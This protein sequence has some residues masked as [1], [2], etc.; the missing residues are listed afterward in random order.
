MSR[1]DIGVL[2]Y[3]HFPA[4][5]L[6]TGKESVSLPSHAFKK[7]Y[8]YTRSDR[9]GVEKWIHRYMHTLHTKR[10]D[11][12]GIQNEDPYPAALT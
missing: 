11:R 1:L 3:H 7:T 12:R 2:P 6:L 4:R 5:G 10:I 8:I 9:L